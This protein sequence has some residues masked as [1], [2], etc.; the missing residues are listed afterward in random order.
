MQ[1]FESVSSSYTPDGSARFVIPN[2]V[3]RD[4]MY[5]YLLAT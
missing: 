5:T 1:N 2:E 4:Q 3:E